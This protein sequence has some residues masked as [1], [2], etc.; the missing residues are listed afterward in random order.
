[1]GARWIN[2]PT[3]RARLIRSKS[4]LSSSCLRLRPPPQPALVIGLTLLSLFRVTVMKLVLLSAQASEGRLRDL[5]A[6]PV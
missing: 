4:R 1:M 3:S 6:L 2:M 5:S